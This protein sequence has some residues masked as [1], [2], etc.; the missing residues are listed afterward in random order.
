MPAFSAAKAG[1][2]D[3]NTLPYYA[4]V[5]FTR[6]QSLAVRDLPCRSLTLDIG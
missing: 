4:T 6:L 2:K 5:C 3:L 1:E